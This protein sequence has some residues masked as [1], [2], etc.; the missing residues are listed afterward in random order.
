MM[1]IL[2]IIT[3]LSIIAI[4]LGL[5][6][7]VEILGGI[8]IVSFFVVLIFGWFLAGGAGSS[9]TVVNYYSP[10]QQEVRFFQYGNNIV[11][12]IQSTTLDEDDLVKADISSLREIKKTEGDWFFKVTEGFNIYGFQNE[13]DVEIVKKEEIDPSLLQHLE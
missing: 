4:I 13:T 11:A 10:H 5:W 1:L 9:E 2:I 8:G 12:R 7:D 3:A 6:L